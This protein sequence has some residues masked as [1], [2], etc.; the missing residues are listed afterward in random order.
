MS[1][2]TLTSLETPVPVVDLDRLSQN[3]DRMA[4][5]AAVHGVSLRPHVKTHKSRRMAAEQ[6]RRGAAGL[7]CA[8]PRELEVMATVTDDLL[9]AY[10]PVGEARARRALEAI[11]EG[12]LTVML[13][14]SV[15]ADTLA[16]AARAVGRTVRVLVE[17]DMGMHRVGVVR[18]ADAVALGT[19]VRG[20]PGLEYA[21][22]GF[23][24]GHIREP[25]D[26]QGAS[27]ARLSSELLA[28]LEL[29]DRADLTPA[30][31]SGSSTPIAWHAHELP[32]VTELRPGTYIYN[33][34]TT[35][36]IGAC[37]WEDCALTVLATVVSTSVGG[38]AVIDAG[39]K[40][41][42]R[43]PLRGA[44]AEKDGWGAVLEHPDV[45]VTR[46]SEEHGVL[47]LSASAWKPSVGEQVRIVP[48]HV[49]YVVA[50]FDEVIGV[51][52]THV[53][54]SWPVDARGRL[55]FAVP[56]RDAPFTPRLA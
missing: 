54:T 1:A 42:G 35:A 45:V 5:Y 47:D 36:M 43:E 48:N 8:T 19:H 37:A 39:S 15:A 14:S 38:Q 40:A 28:L 29:L 34:R 49:C 3:L 32:R 22:I 20:T 26:R 30:V 16:R 56:D 33:D 27:L 7:T 50:L 17:I 55:P 18:A 46:M 10:P 9:L 11:G 4:A 24:P 44:G 53:E 41:L 51:R 13:D 25:V 2:E 6:L 31:V 52:G 23:Y 12:T 21:G